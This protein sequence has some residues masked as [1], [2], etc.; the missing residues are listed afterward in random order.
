MRDPGFMNPIGAP[1]PLGDSSRI[2]WGIFVLT[3]GARERTRGCSPQAYVRLVSRLEA[4][5]LGT[6]FPTATDYRL[7]CLIVF[8]APTTCAVGWIF[9]SGLGGPSPR[10]PLGSVRVGQVSCVTP[11][12]VCTTRGVELTSLASMA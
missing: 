2:V 4:E 1:E 5:Q 12:E 10:A 8:V 7:G 3:V 11:F 9:E 6:L